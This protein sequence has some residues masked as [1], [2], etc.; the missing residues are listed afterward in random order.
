MSLSREQQIA[1]HMC[2]WICMAQSLQVL[3]LLGKNINL[4]Q[5]VCLE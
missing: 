1:A 5:H 4:Q 2:N 3:L